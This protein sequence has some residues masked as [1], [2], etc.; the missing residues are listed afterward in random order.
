MSKKTTGKE[1]ANSAIWI[2]LSHVFLGLPEWMIE[3]GINSYYAEDRARLNSE[4]ID[5][6][7]A[8]K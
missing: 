8:Q 3:T 7:K 4:F 5:F 1:L 6:F 2:Y